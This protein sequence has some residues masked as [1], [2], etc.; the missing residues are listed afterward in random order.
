VDAQMNKYG[1][2]REREEGG[3]GVETGII[4]VA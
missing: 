1:R 3:G 4:E 2:R